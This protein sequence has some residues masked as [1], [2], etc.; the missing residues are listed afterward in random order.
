MAA[1]V[2][3]KVLKY[4]DLEKLVNHFAENADIPH[5][6]DYH[7]EAYDVHCLCVIGYAVAKYEAGEVSEEVLLAACLH[8]VKKPQKAFIKKDG[9]AAFDGHENVTDWEIAEFLD[10]DYHNFARV[11]ELVR[12][13]SLPWQKTDSGKFEKRY[14]ALIEKYGRKFGEDLDLLVVCDHGGGVTREVNLPAAMKE[15]EKIKAFLLRV[16]AMK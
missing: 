8:D 12:G 13:H 15:A 6:C 16:A 10:S 14:N 5:V 1:D 3:E 7:K 2:A 9:Q 11:A 4:L